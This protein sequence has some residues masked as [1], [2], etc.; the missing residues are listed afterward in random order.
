MNRIPTG[1]GGYNC[2]V[3]RTGAGTGTALCTKI[4]TEQTAMNVACFLRPVLRLRYGTHS[5]AVG[6]AQ[7]DMDGG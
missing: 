5:R 3:K 6:S 2:D 4:S 7:D 1:G